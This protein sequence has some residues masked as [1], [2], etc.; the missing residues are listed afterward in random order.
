MQD[1]EKREL[2]V[3]TGKELLERGLVARTWGNVSCRADDGAFLVTP[4]GLDYTL[5]TPE[6]IVLY[7]P[8]GSFEGRRKPSGEKGVH[9]VAYEMFP[10]VNF[11]IHTHQ[12]YAT[13]LGLA[14]W[15]DFHLTA[16]ETAAIG[17]VAWAEYG[18]PG[19]KKLKENVRDAMGTGARVV[20]MAHHGVMVCGTDKDDAMAR[21][22]ALE[23]VCEQ[24][25]DIPAAGKMDAER[26]KALM[27][28]VTARHPMARLCD[29]DAVLACCDKPM[30]ARLDDMAQMIGRTIGTC[31]ADVGTIAAALEKKNAVLVPGLGCVVRGDSEDDSYALTVLVHKAAVSQ[32]HCENYGVGACLSRLDCALMRAV[33]VTKY[34]KQKKG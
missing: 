21:V 26:A 29:T 16:E 19:Q 23:K 4:S 18:L 20:L 1:R 27:D 8:D 2:I 32:C 22:M 10:D 6:D 34:S 11:V 13:A 15:E 3:A 33:Y 5:T 17:N 7:K 31:S 9:A 30:V 14:G 25:V 12:T 24:L 28:K